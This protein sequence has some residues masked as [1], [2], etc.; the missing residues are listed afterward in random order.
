MYITLPKSE[1]DYCSLVWNW[2]TG[3][4]TSLNIHVANPLCI[5][6]VVTYWWIFPPIHS[7]WKYHQLHYINHSSAQETNLLVGVD[8][9]FPL[10]KWYGKIMAAS[11][12]NNP[13]RVKL[14]YRVNNYEFAH[15]IN[16]T[17]LPMLANCNMALGCMLKSRC[18]PAHTSELQWWHPY[19][20]ELVELPKQCDSVGDQRTHNTWGTLHGANK[21]HFY[22]Q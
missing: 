19:G 14:H 7:S 8:G 4:N 15:M 22:E 1:I 20:I 6:H 9:H 18:K 12:F 10:I 16:N 3:L 13:I 17:Y 5:M 11:V 21:L 2:L